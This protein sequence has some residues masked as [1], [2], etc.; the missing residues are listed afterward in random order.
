MALMT[1]YVSTATSAVM[2]SV[3]L[4]CLQLLNLVPKPVEAVVLLIPAR[5]KHEELAKREEEE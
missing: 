4:L 2:P 3:C 5:G 1:K